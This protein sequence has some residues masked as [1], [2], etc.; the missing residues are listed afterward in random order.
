R[1]ARRELRPDLPIAP[2]IQE[3]GVRC[4]ARA[5]EDRYQS[6]DELLAQLKVVRTA[7]TGVAG[8]V[9]LPPPAYDTQP[10]LKPL[11]P[12]M[13]AQ[14]PPTPQPGLRTPSQ[15]MSA[16]RPTP[17]RGMPHVVRPPPPPPEALFDE[18]DSPASLPLVA[19]SE[20]M[21][22]PAPETAPVSERKS[23]LRPA[24]MLPAAVA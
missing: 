19:P 9:S 10:N 16:L 15:P 5:G 2:D 3:I 18:E 22:P 24:V 14:T 4:M 23:M 7:I 13:I 17:A 11:S 1:V 12:P 21:A 6:M 20:P 8:A